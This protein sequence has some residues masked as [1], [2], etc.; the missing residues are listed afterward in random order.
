MD[1]TP[2]Y[3]IELDK[4]LERRTIF[5]PLTKATAKKLTPRQQKQLDNKA[6]K[7]AAVTALRM[8]TKAK[9]I[10]DQLNKRKNSPA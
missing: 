7:I 5:E 2:N 3:D 1:T 4:A 9:C 8:R 10:E 6:R